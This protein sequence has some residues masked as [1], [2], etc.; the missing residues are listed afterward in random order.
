MNSKLLTSLFVGL[1]IFLIAACQGADEIKKAQFYTNGKT[2]YTNNCGN[3]HGE[4]GDGLG[5]LYPPLSDTTSIAQKRRQLACIV[6]YGMHETLNIG[7][8][9]FDT[10]MPGS[11]Q[12]SQ[13]EIAYILT[14]VGNSFGNDLGLISTEEVEAS[15]KNCVAEIQP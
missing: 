7:Q 14:Y 3:C 13:Q 2:L 8:Q 9:T 4:K 5:K 1:L 15:L 12:L 10:E 6:K 11:P